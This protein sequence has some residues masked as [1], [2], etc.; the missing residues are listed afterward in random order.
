MTN[1]RGIDSVIAEHAIAM[2]LALAHGLDRFA[3]HTAQKE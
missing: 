3:L 2:M 1:M